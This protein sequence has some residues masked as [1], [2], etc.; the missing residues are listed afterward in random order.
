M[1]RGKAAAPK[2]AAPAKPKA[3][4]ALSDVLFKEWDRDEDG[5]L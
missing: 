2:K 5:Q 1:F 3:E 4:P